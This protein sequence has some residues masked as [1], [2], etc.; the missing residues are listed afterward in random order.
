MHHSKRFRQNYP[1]II[2]LG[3]FYFTNITFADG[4]YFF[5]QFKDKHN[6]PFSLD[7]PSEFL[8]I[9]S[10][11]RRA[12]QQIAIDSTDLPVNPD[13]IAQ[14]AN[15]GVRIHSASKWINGV[16][17][18]SEDSLPINGISTL[19][20]VERVEYT[21]KKQDTAPSFSRVKHID[22]DLNYDAA[23]SQIGQLHAS[24]LHQSGYTGKDIL[25]GIL[26]GGFKNADINPAFDSL[27]LQNRLLGTRNII[28]SSVDVYRGD[29]HGAKVLSIMAANLPNVFS[30][31]APHASYWLIETEYIPTEYMVEVDFWVRGLEF[32]DSIGVDIINSSLGYTEFDDAAMNFTYADMNGRT[33]RASRAA[34]LASRKG[35]LVCISAGNDGNNPW[36]YISSP[37]DAEGILAVGAVNTNNSIAAFSS[38]GPTADNRI[39]PD[40]CATGWGTALINPA[41]QLSYENGTSY[42]SPIIAGLTACYLQH[43]KEQLPQPYSIDVIIQ[44]IISSADRYDNPDPQ[45]GYGLPNFQQALHTNAVNGKPYKQENKLI[46]LYKTGKISISNPQ[47]KKGPALLRIFSPTGKVIHTKTIN[48]QH[49]TIDISHLNSGIYLVHISHPFF[50]EGCKIIVP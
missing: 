44:Q 1:I 33:S 13:Y 9:K 4:Y 30:G 18:F 40:L 23:A 2:L 8:D 17:V 19:P 5:V 11:Q 35:I 15:Q 6:S 45:Y 38:F 25:I 16:T 34:F 26:D 36:K 22:K 49:E 32:A 50:S 20:F 43:H 21:G 28:N 37:A 39:K 24:A 12:N 31:V 27:R 10:I 3:L 47:A 29:A 41:G 14:V 42:A 7:R 46:Y 48:K